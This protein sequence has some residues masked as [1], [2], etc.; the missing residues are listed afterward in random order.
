MESEYQITTISVENQ[1]QLEV[2]DPARQNRGFKG[3]WI[4]R[5][6]WLEKDLSVMEKVILAEVNSLDGERGCFAS[7]KYFANFLGISEG[8]TAHLLADLI[9]RGYIESIGFNG[10]FRKIRLGKVAML[11]TANQISYKQQATD[12]ENSI[13]ITKDI[14]KDISKDIESDLGKSS[15]PNA[16]LDQA[17]EEDFTRSAER[18]KSLWNEFSGHGIPPIRTMTRKRAQGLSRRVLEGMDLSQVLG[19]AKMSDFL[20]GKNDRGWKMTLDWLIENDT[21]WVK[22]MEGKYDNVKQVKKRSFNPE[23]NLY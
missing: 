10:R 2:I 3:V 18:A 1:S 22:V 8:R 16:N 17:K 12:A 11:K 7:N 15:S 21:N 9:K 6:I 4:P 13:H 19:K 20:T 14:K 23:R 5:E